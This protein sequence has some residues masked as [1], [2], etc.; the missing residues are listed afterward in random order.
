V[1]PALALLAAVV[2][3]RAAYPRLLERRQERRRAV[4][5]D[6]LV[7]G[8]AP[9]DLPRANAPGVLLLHGGGD[10]PQALE[11][12]AQHLH[13]RGFAVRVPLLSGHGRHLSA[14]A[15]SSARQWHDDVRREFEAMRAKHDRVAIVGL[16]MGGSLAVKLASEC[17]V[18][19]LV[20]LAPYVDMPPFARGMALTSHAW[21][22]LLPYFSSLGTRSIRDPS[23]AARALGHGILTPAALRALY[24]VVNDAVRALPRVTAPALVIQSREDNRIPPESAERGFARLGSAKKRFIWTDGAAHVITVDFGHQRVFEMTTDWLEAHLHV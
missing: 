17:D 10:T 24:D 19:A 3:G 6:G 4:G 22:W 21:G 9:I 13:K 20:L 12:L 14:L 8:A 16:S 7:K 5:P 15:A 2:V 23:A 11:Q 1:L 18:D